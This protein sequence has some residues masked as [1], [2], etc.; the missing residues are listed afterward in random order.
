MGTKGDSEMLTAGPQRRKT[1]RAKAKRSRASKR[2]AAVWA[3]KNHNNQAL[4][5]EEVDRLLASAL[6]Y[7]EAKRDLIDQRIA[8][9]RTATAS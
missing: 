8:A 3:K 4:R 1:R 5:T 6:R 9:I 2:P 7:W